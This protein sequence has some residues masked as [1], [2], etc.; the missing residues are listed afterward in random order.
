MASLYEISREVENDWYK[1]AR[2]TLEKF[3][4]EQVQKYTA[5]LLKCLDDLA[6]GKGQVKEIKISGHRVLIKRCEK[7]YIFALSETNQPILIIAILHEQMDLMQRL[8]S[9]LK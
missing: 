1:I 6:R 3:G 8:Q 9:R 5:S 4:E 2:Y 7:H